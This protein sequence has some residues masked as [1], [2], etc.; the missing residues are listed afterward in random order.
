MNS[1]VIIKSKMQSNGSF[2]IAQFL[3]EGIGQSGKPSHCHSHSEILSFDIAGTDML[4]VRVSLSDLGYRLHDW[5]WGV[6]RFAV[7]LAIVAVQLHKLREI[8]VSAKRVLNG[9]YVK[10]KTVC[11]DLYAIG[12]TLREIV[13]QDI[14]R[15]LGAF[16]YNKRRNQFCL[17][18]NGHENPLVANFGSIILSDSSLFLKAE[19]PDFIALNEFAGKFPHSS[20]QQLGAALACQNQK[21]Q[22]SVTVQSGKA[23]GRAHRAA[24]QQ[25]LQGADSV[26]L[27]NPH[28][29]K[30]LG[31]GF[32]KGSTAGS[33]TVTLDSVLTVA[34]KLLNF[35]VLAFY[36]GHGFSPLV[37]EWEKP[38]TQF[39]SGVRLIPCFG[40]APLTVPAESG[41]LSYSIKFLGW[42]FNRDFHGLT[43]SEADNNF[44]SQHRC[45][46]LPECPVSAGHSYLLRK[47][48]TSASNPV[49]ICQSIQ[50]PV[51]NCQRIRIFPQIV[52]NRFNLAFNVFGGHWLRRHTHTSKNQFLYSDFFRFLSRIF[53][54]FTHS[55]K[56]LYQLL[57]TSNFHNP[58][59]ALISCV[60]KVSLCLNQ[61]VF[62]RVNSH[63]NLNQSLMRE[64]YA[65]A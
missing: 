39:G 22:D 21:T 20:V 59:I 31:I 51:D 7:M 9:A 50:C 28:I 62:V 55:F 6:F 37:S 44:E 64:Y 14:C 2:Q 18:V 61:S 46:I 4:R 10:A 15:T 27:F 19:R 52:A 56:R 17:R 43:G 26:V 8:N 49:G 16:A 45:F 29:A 25:A 42:R 5:A 32:R 3:R 24:L 36:A 11:G 53:T 1:T 54:A 13:N 12:Q 38:Y 60:L 34:A 33:A 23:L 48:I 35:R 47:N 58:F 57:Q 41:A 30:G 40:L 65:I 63:L